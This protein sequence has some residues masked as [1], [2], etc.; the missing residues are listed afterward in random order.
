MY[1]R[2]YA[3]ILWLQACG[4]E[5][6]YLLSCSHVCVCL[7]IRK[8]CASAKFQTSW[9]LRHC[10]CKSKSS[11]FLMFQRGLW[12]LLQAPPVMLSSGLQQFWRSDRSRADGLSFS[13]SDE[14]QNG[15]GRM[16]LAC[17][18]LCLIC[19]FLPILHP[20]PEYRPHWRCCCSLGPRQ[21]GTTIIQVTSL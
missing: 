7:R 20:S 13:Q 16:L 5:L 2:Q 1:T 9:L 4:E 15:S 11:E 10:F 14:R 21:Q 12:L 18:R 3:W 19:Y 17:S 6:Q 8:L